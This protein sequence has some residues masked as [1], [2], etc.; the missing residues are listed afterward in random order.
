ME[1][2]ESKPG[3]TNTQGDLADRFAALQRQAT[4]LL[5]G[6]VVVSGTLSVFLWRQSHYARVDLENAK[7]QALPVL[8]TFKQ[9]EKPN[10]DK[11][12]NQL[13]EFA[14]AHPDFGQLLTLYRIQLP[15]PAASSAEP[16]SAAPVPPKSAAAPATSAPPTAT[17]APTPAPTKK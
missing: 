11:L 5:V 17:K 7:A 16:S 14:R 9:Y 15:T 6:L 8:Q 3:M 2:L 12:D 13:A 4:V 10:F 1:N